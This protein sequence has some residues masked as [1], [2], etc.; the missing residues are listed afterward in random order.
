MGLDAFRAYVTSLRTAYPDFK[1]TIHEQ[2]VK[3]DKIIT[4]WTVTGTNT[5]PTQT[6]MG[7]VPP[8]N[9]AMSVNG[10]EIIIVVDGKITE[11][12][13]FYNQLYVYMQLGYTL[14]PPQP[15]EEIKE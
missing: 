11:D 12:W 13:V 5:G 15:P 14:T 9:K 4:R 6:P 3:G 7:E 1:A 2:I 10:A 8:T